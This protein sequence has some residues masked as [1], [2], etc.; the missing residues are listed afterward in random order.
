MRYYPI[1]LTL[2]LFGCSAD[3][4]KVNLPENPKTIVSTAPSITETLFE[5]GLGERVVGVSRFCKFPEEIKTRNIKNVG[6][7]FDQNRETVLAL[8]P[9]AV[10]VLR[11]DNDRNDFYLK[12]GFKVIL[13]NQSNVNVNE[14]L[15]SFVQIGEHFDEITLAKSKSLCDLQKLRLAEIEKE[16]H[17]KEPLR[18]LLCIDRDRTGTGLKSIYAA[19]GNRLYNDALRIVG[20]VNVLADSTFSAPQISVESIL[21]ANPDV[22]IDISQST[23]SA[24]KSKTDSIADWQAL[25]DDV[26]AVKYNRVFSTEAEYATIPGPRFIL[27]IEWLAKVLKQDAP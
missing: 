21:R 20:A 26:N 13:V 2:L 6:G 4:T 22:I 19:G 27:F 3:N 16:M 9:D 5:L 23:Q 10:C 17:K 8:N 11:E 1:I 7:L 18:V 24:D 25:K 12:S 15:E 14:L